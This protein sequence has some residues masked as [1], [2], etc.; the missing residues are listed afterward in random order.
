MNMCLTLLYSI[1]SVASHSQ[2]NATSGVHTEFIQGFRYQM[3]RNNTQERDA[4][5]AESAGRLR[6]DVECLED[7]LQI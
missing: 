3:E 6:D 4:L 7:M 1:L 2:T 5:A